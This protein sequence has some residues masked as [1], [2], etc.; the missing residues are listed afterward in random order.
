MLLVSS[1]L[2]QIP[3]NAIAA[4][5]AFRDIYVMWGKSK[6][7]ILVLHSMVVA[8]IVSDIPSV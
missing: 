1:D 6:K 7:A 5:M 4:C 8:R 3:A 2:N